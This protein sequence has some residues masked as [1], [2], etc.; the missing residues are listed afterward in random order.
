MSSDRRHANCPQQCWR[1]RRRHEQRRSRACNMRRVSDWLMERAGRISVMNM[2]PPKVFAIPELLEIILVGVGENND[3]AGIK[4]L[5][6]LQSVNS[7]FDNVIKNSPKLRRIMFKQGTDSKHDTEAVL[8]PLC[9]DESKQ[10]ILCPTR[11]YFWDPLWPVGFPASETQLALDLELVPGDSL[12]PRQSSNASWRTLKISRCFTP[13]TIA[14]AVI[15]HDNICDIRFSTHSTLGE[16]MDQVLGS[17][18]LR[19]L[20]R[21]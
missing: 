4:S 14:C 9:F 17:H 10:R 8:N 15:T 21:V 20:E 19:D 1:R 16:L 12:R 2:A 13:R 6:V 7:T 3:L 18:V 11:L 5:F